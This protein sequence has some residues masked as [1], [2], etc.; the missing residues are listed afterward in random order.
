MN[1]KERPQFATPKANTK[2]RKKPYRKSQAVKELESIANIAAR[3]KFP[4]IPPEWLSPRNYRDDSANGLTKCIIDFLKF[5][6][7]H[8]ERI[9]NTGRLIDNQRTFIDAIGRTRTIGQK[10][11][12]KGTG[13]NGTADISATING[14]SV[15]VEVKYKNDI[16]SEAQRTYQ[17]HIEQAGGIYFIAR[18][19]ED[20]Y[21]WY[22]TK[23]KEDES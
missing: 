15:K 5:K 7:N 11:W 8:A 10:K 14:L 16:Q 17:C 20:F 1:K 4:E 3:K 13:T 23:F 12:I 18:T 19:F 21:N 2:I 9:N 6:G 22:N